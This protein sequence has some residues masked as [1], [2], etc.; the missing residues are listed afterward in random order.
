[1]KLCAYQAMLLITPSEANHIARLPKYKGQEYLAR[2]LQLGPIDDDENLK[3]ALL[4]DY[5]YDVLQFSV[6]RGLRWKEVVA[7]LNFASEFLH[8]AVGSTLPEAVRVLHRYSTKY[9]C[10]GHLGIRSAKLLLEYFTSTFLAHFKLYKHVMTRAREDHT[11][12]ERLVVEVPP[13]TMKL[14]DAVT[15]QV[16]EYEC[17]MKEIDAQETQNKTELEELRHKLEEKIGDV[18]HDIKGKFLE[19]DLESLSLDD[20]EKL[21]GEIAS[22]KLALL[23]EDVETDI[24]ELRDSTNI[25]LRRQ[26]HPLPPGWQK[27]EG[28]MPKQVENAAPQP[29]TTSA[30]PTSSRKK[31]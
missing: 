19:G 21:I 17:K 7:C 14:K 10:A 4:V 3:S 15:L 9:V 5:Y 29:H 22:K 31:K 12:S 6:N 24:T 11:G 1:M 30:K 26:S 23:Q 2:K 25:A 27:S 8:S 13:E 16:H 28:L 18:E 20:A